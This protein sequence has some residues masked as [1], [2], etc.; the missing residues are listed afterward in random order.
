MEDKVKDEMNS[1]FTWEER[2]AIWYEQADDPEG[3]PFADFFRRRHRDDRILTPLEEKIRALIAEE[4]PKYLAQVS[5][6]RVG[7]FADGGWFQVQV[8]FKCKAEREKEARVTQVLNSI[9]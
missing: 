9:T 5:D 7:L 1:E 3:E 2:M 4:L 8:Q 6:D